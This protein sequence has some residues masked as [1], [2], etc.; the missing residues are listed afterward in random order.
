MILPIL[1]KFSSLR[2]NLLLLIVLAFVAYAVS[3]QVPFYFDDFRFLADPVFVKHQGLIAVWQAEPARVLTYSTLYLNHLLGGD[4]PWG[5][6]L[7]NL[8]FHMATAATV[9]LL[10]RTLSSAPNSGLA[11]SGDS[12]G[13]AFVAVVAAC[14]FTAHPLNTQ[15]VT[16]IVQRAA[17]LSAL[18]YVFAIFAYLKARLAPPGMGRKKWLAICAGAGIC[19][20]LS[21]QNTATL[22]LSLLLIEL[23]FFRINRR[24]IAVLGGIILV[25]LAVAAATIISGKL[26]L[27]SLDLATRET[28]AL[29]RSE[30]LAIQTQVLWQYISLFCF[31]LGL[32]LEY[33]PPATS[34]WGDTPVILATI[35]H[36]AILG[37]AFFFAR[38]KPIPAFGMLLFYT[39]H[40]VESSV[41]P[42]RDIVFEHRTYL[43][44]VGL[45]IVAGWLVNEL[46]VRF[47]NWRSLLVFATAVVV[48]MLLTVTVQRNLLWRDPVAFFEQNTR[49]EP[50]NVR[51]W[52]HLST[53]YIDRKNFT[54]A[55]RA[56]QKVDRARLNSTTREKYFVNVVISLS[57]M[58]NDD[59]AIRVGKELLDT[60]VVDDSAQRAVV[61]N[62]MAISLA[63]LGFGNQAMR[64]LEEALQLNPNNQEVIKNYAT[65]KNAGFR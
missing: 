51:A 31:P 65:M 46:Y 41:L 43:P 4:A 50:N 39:A 45:C 18:F 57:G 30:Y 52:G 19:A 26:S 11:F 44:N 55:Y 63:R 7:V 16:Y 38:K 12:S 14:I 25:L 1:E 58:K 28:D 3:F 35:S 47:P 53:E 56:L 10:V 22:P 20:L 42:I 9:L 48:A 21:K 17:V 64:S 54:A 27:E 36:L 62:T 34:A 40:L 2:W 33:E 6:H 23:I 24:T 60:K 37:I 49:L 5:Y 13:Y 61:L 32:R 15:A 29:T 8:L 59:D